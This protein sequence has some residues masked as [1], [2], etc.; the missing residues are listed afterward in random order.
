MKLPKL[1]IGQRYHLIN[2]DIDIVV[3]FEE[4]CKYSVAGY[5]VLQSNC[6]TEYKNIIYYW[7]VPNN[8][9]RVIMWKYLL[10]QDARKVI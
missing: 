9:N 2:G 5:R 8:K 10:N 3:Q 4:N 6:K 1:Q 7:S